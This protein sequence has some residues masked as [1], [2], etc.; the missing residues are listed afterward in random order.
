MAHSPYNNSW[1]VAKV[2]PEV[3]PISQA[4]LA[5][6]VAQHVSSPHEKIT[7]GLLIEFQWHLKLSE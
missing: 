7:H 5:R 6:C 3:L 2:A 1:N 4:N